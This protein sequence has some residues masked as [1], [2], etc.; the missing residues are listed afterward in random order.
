MLVKDI[1]TKNTLICLA[2]INF[3]PNATNLWRALILWEACCVP[4]LLHR[5][6]TWVEMFTTTEEKK[7][8]CPPS[9]V[10]FQVL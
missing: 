5:A 1:H 10:S 7:T 6:G 8:E 3:S 2:M 9:L 4:N